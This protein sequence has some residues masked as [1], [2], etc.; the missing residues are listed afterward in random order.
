MNSLSFLDRLA[1]VVQNSD[2]VS[3]VGFRPANPHEKA[4]LE[5]GFPCEGRWTMDYVDTF[6]DDNAFDYAKDIA[7]GL[8]GTVCTDEGEI[9]S[10]SLLA[11][12]ETT[13][14][15]D[16]YLWGRLNVDAYTKLC[17]AN[18]NGD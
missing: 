9:V 5:N 14:D 6:Y 13:I 1:F 17:D 2:N 16:H 10:D 12:N 3:L 18:Y 4:D 15:G 8:W 11:W 7:D